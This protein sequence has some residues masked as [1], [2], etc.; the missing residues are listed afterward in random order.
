MTFLYVL[1]LLTIFA[2]S[3]TIII[4]VVPQWE[5]ND[6]KVEAKKIVDFDTTQYS[7]IELKTMYLARYDKKYNSL[8]DLKW[9]WTVKDRLTQDGCINQSQ[10]NNIEFIEVCKDGG[11]IGCEESKL[12][13]PKAY[14]NFNF[15]DSIMYANQT[16]WKK[17]GD[18]N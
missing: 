7:C 8:T 6:A 17:L 13:Y 2:V 11:T 14:S 3:L 4:V 5:A 15:R 16:N 1:I 18:Y 9:Y 12:R 10:L